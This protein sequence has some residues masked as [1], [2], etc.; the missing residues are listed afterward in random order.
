MKGLH[1][2]IVSTLQQKEPKCPIAPSS[3]S[4]FDREMGQDSESKFPSAPACAAF[5]RDRGL[6]DEEPEPDAG[7]SACCV[8]RRTTAGP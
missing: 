3:F 7:I 6:G 8:T 4:E 2:R 1:L 5:G